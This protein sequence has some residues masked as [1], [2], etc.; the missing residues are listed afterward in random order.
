MPC[1]CVDFKKVPCRPIGLK[2]V[3]CRMAPKPK[4][5]HVAVSIL[6]VYT[7]VVSVE[8]AFSWDV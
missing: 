1:H 8:Y 4:K 7:I 3:P 2:K 5:G 6:G